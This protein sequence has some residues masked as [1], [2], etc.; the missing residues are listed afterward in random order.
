MKKYLPVMLMTFVLLLTMV[1][2]STAN[3]LQQLDVV[4]DKVEAK[5]DAAEDK[6]EDTLRE[7]VNPAPA[8]EPA[9]TQPVAEPRQ[10]Q[11]EPV[12]TQPPVSESAQRLTE[13]QVQKIALDYLGYTADQVTRLRSSFEIDDGFPQYDVE[14]YAGDWEYEFEIH[15]EDGRILSYDKDHKYD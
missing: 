14:F 7:A 2:C 11:S 3:A 9:P 12:Q 1:G 5:L 10:E 13:E 6:L 15:A 4:E 8:A